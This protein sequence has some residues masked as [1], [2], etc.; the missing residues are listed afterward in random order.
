MNTNLLYIPLRQSLPIDL[1]QELGDVINR[2]YFQP[3]STFQSDLSLIANLRNTISNIKNEQVTKQDEQALLK[4]LA[5][6]QIIKQKF[7]DDCIEFGW[8]GSL[9]YGPFKSRSLVIEEMSILFQLGSVYSQFGLKE[10]RHTDTGLKNACSYFQ[11]AAGCFKSIS[12]LAESTKNIPPEFH[13]D[14]MGC[15][16]YMMLAQAQ[17]TIWQKALGNSTMKDSVI[18]KLSFQTSEYYSQALSLGNSSDYIKLEWINHLAV[19]KFHF[20]AAAYFRK[21]NIAQD[22]FNYGEQVAYLRLASKSLDSGAKYKRYVSQLVLDDFQG[23]YD[24]IKSVLK[25]A[26]RDNDL[27]YLKVVPGEQDLPPLIGVSMVNPGQPQ[28]ITIENPFLKDLLPYIIIHVAQAFRE[29][30]DDFIRERFYDPIQALNT[31]FAKYISDRGLPA[32]IDSVQQSENIPDSIIHHSREFA[33]MGGTSSIEDSLSK[34]GGLR[35]DCMHIV[36]ECEKRITLDDELL[37]NKTQPPQELLAK[38]DKMKQYLVQAKTGDDVV[39]NKF[40]GVKP[41]LEIYTKGYDGLISFIPN[42]SYTKLDEDL[43]AVISDLRKILFE[44]DNVRKKRTEFLEAIEIKSRDNNILPR[45]IDEYKTNYNLYESENLKELAFEPV[46]EQHIQMFAE[47]VKFVESSKE[48]Q[49]RLEQE[50]DVLNNRFHQEANLHQSS[51]QSKRQEALQSLET[52][53]SMY[54]EIVG[55][56]NEGSKFY[57]DFI[58]KSNVVLKEC[59]DYLYRKRIEIRDEQQ[60][61]NHTPVTAPADVIS[62]KTTKAVWNPQSGIKFS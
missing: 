22:S 34:I 47:D 42:T 31:M 60:Q 46:Y 32:S 12:A 13:K 3:S 33:N 52:A 51:S 19:K 4:F 9:A 53:Y 17:E 21:A 10:S 28:N 1:G 5:Y 25:S 56:L 16:T 6:L 40:L 38:I 14:T 44:I 41:Y 20:Q 8:L 30:Q 37:G 2:D 11:L 55:N 39:L 7:S 36:Q 24:T 62:P 57:T 43:I 49:I 26:E 59:E 50:L 23:L 58:T 35:Q 18:S 61:H 27:I 45:L 48:L 29:R 15:L 54:L